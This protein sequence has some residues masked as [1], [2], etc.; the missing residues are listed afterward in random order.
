MGAYSS[1][2]M[3]A[4]THHFLVQLCAKRCGHSKWFTEYAVLGDDIVISDRGVADQY[5]RLMDELGV[6]IGFHKSI[7]SNNS[8]LEFAKRFFL[9]GEEV[10][11]LSLAGIAVGWLGPGFVPE[12]LATCESKTGKEITLYQLARYVGVGF[13]AASAAGSRLLT[14]LPRVLTSTLLLLLRPGAP[15]GVSSLLEWYTA[16]TMSGSNSVKLKVANEEQIFDAIWKEVTD[17]DL[18]NALNR[19]QTVLEELFKPDNGKKVLGSQSFRY[20]VTRTDLLINYRE[21][22]HDIIVPSFLR[23]FYPAIDHAGRVLSDAMKIWARER[24]LRKSLS[25][26]EECFSILSLIPNRL[27]L[28]RREVEEGFIPSEMDVYRVLVPGSVR[29]WS[30]VASFTER[31]APH[32]LKPRRKNR[33]S[34]EFLAYANKR[35]LRA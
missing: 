30:K 5:V 29:R 21:W 25:L 4:L 6:R 35:M 23:R 32:M 20:L 34:K 11:P 2:A 9:K 17:R 26:V 3:L 16:L 15:R 24:N 27:S 28:V 19:A 33:V 1:W 7:I 8:S 22:F 13:K 14:K 10:S 12:I 18:T 31:K